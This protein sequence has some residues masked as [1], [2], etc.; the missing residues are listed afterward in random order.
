[1]DTLTIRS[2]YQVRPLLFWEDLSEYEKEEYR[3]VLGD[4]DE[5][6]FFRYKGN[7]YLLS[8]FMILESNSPFP[9]YWQG[10]MSDSF[11]SGILIRLVDQGMEDAVIVGQYFS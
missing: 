3:D 5:H 11:F 10:Y 6:E 9:E 4:P 1:M 2:N 7:I 8:D